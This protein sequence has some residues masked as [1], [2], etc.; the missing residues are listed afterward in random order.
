LQPPSPTYQKLVTALLKLKVLD[1]N[2]HRSRLSPEVLEAMEVR[3]LWLR[4]RLRALWLRQRVFFTEDHRRHAG[5]ASRRLQA[6][7]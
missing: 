4:K 2:F 1:N 6:A 3:R 7:R 5:S